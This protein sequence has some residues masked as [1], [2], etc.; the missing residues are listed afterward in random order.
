MNEDRYGNLGGKQGYRHLFA[1][2]D[3]LEREWPFLARELGRAPARSVVDLGCGPGEHLGR[4]TAEGWSAVGID[5]SPAQIE[6]AQRHH[7][8]VEFHVGSMDQLSSLTDRSFGAALCL[9]NVM[10]NIEDLTFEKT[11]AQLGERLL[12]GA[13]LVLQLLEFTRI[14]SGARRAIG[15]TFRPPRPGSAEGDE[16]MFLRVFTQGPDPQHVHFLPMTFTL[17]AYAEPAVDFDP[18]HRVVHRAWTEP[19][20]REHLVAAGFVEVRAFGSL[21]G[22]DHDPAQSD[23]L[24][25][26]ARRPYEGAE[27]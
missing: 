9:G 23:D 11:L 2:S 13:V 6:S 4:L 1:W 7:P 5:L 16:T 19:E 17:H 25:L 20:L 3:R 27:D 24:V 26:V 10:P 14:L 8:Q 18:V 21:Q 12:P 22:E 15:P